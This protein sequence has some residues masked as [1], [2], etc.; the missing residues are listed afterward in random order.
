MPR[1]KDCIINNSITDA[2]FILLKKKHINDISITELIQKA[3]V[4]RN[5]FYRN[6]ETL[7]D[8]A[9]KFFMK[10]ANMWWENRVIKEHIQ[11]TNAIGK[12]L[13][14]HFYTIK[15]R[16]ILTYEKG[17]SSAF[18]KHIF[19]CAFRER[20]ANDKQQ[21][22]SVARVAGLICGLMNEWVKG[23]MTDNPEYVAS[24]LTPQNAYKLL[25]SNI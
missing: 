25:N 12:S 8:I 22:Y 7:E 24:F 18:I 20:N 14:E 16:I 2:L 5:S 19:D 6:F 17:L 1:R 10:E 21:C 11:D 4:S 9:Y 15:E 13:F 3:G 23:K